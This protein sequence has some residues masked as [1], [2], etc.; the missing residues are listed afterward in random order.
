MSYQPKVA[1]E[2][3]GDTLHVYSGGK[4]KV[5]I[6][7][8]I[9]HN[10][11]SLVDEIA[12]LS[13]LDSG[14]LGILEGASAGS[15]TAS[16]VVSRD[17]AKNIPLFGAVL[18]ALGN[19][20]G[21]AAAVAAQVTLVTA[22]NGTKAVVLPTAVVGQ[23]FIVV[24]TVANATLPVYPASGAQIN[25][26][27]ADAALTLGPGQV[28]IFHCTALLTWYV[29]GQAA[30]TA[31]TTELGYAAGVT[32]G[33]ATASKFAGLGAT[34]NLDTLLID[35]A[36]PAA[37]GTGVQGDGPLTA[38]TNFVTGANDAAV[39][40]TLPTAV[41]GRRLFI[42][43]TVANKYLRVYPAAGAAI[44]A[45]GANAVLQVEASSAVLLYAASATQWWA[46]A[47][48]TTAALT[49][50]EIAFLDGATAGTPV[51][52]KAQIADA[53]Q[54]IGAVKATSLA[55]GPTGAEV[56]IAS[57]PAQLDAAVA[58]T[59][60]VYRTNV[61]VAQI[62]AGATAVVPAV[63]GQKFQ[64]LQILMRSNG[65]AADATTVAVTEETAGTVFL[66]HVI[67]DL[68]DGAWNNH[69]NGTPVITGITAGGTTGVANKALLLT[70][71]GAALTGAASVDV[72]VVGFYTTT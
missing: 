49:P 35:V 43:N 63:A 47:L 2:D 36:A 20:Q 40:V 5:D 17:A 23:T 29:Q 21:T 37:A 13:G 44:N 50:A 72:I 4:V 14:E 34:K 55:V 48:P 12:A 1:R 61:T 27:G 64:V 7:G 24:N 59:P 19:S 32:P 22:S 25:G 10:G 66:S 53:N 31:T 68:T 70:K 46:I 9:E 18:A 26:G 62:N 15:L 57:T 51:A 39:A 65:A 6:G 60:L 54:N 8:D 52:S 11:V 69:V 42:V 33:T 58:G 56:V 30:A 3:G 28:G 38:D 45:L 67:A 41:A 71:T 16:K